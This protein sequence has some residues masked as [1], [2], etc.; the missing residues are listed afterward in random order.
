VVICVVPALLSLP[1]AWLAARLAG[2]KL[3]VHVQDFE[4]EAAFATGL[5]AGKGRVVKWAEAAENRLLRRADRISSISPQMCARLVKKG[6]HPDCVVQI[7]NW[8]DEPAPDDPGKAESLREGWGLGENHVALYSGNIAN[9]QGIAILIEAARLTAHRGDITWVICG[10]G[11]YRARLERLAEGLG[12]VQFH[13]LQPTGRLQELLA[14]AA[15]HLLPQMPGTEDL[16][17]PSKLTNMLASGRPVV[18]TA[19]SGTGLFDE[20]E[21]CGVLT[22][23]GDAATLAR[24]VCE[25]V[26]DPERRQVLGQAA[27]RRARERWARERI[28]DR[29][30][31]EL[32]LVCRDE[33]AAVGQLGEAR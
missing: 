18:A 15:V 14:M 9:K 16:V 30:E 33:P 17:L 13:N 12:N 6:I 24:T 2:A 31:T 29:L 10:Q 21:G 7:R 26:D 20:V 1:V 25:L 5:I 27:R 32:L 11:P 8:A 22:P 23:P 3:W 4:V 28:I 19:N